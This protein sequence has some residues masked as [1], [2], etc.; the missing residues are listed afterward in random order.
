MCDFGPL[1]E[2]PKVFIF[3]HHGSGRHFPHDGT[4]AA[5]SASTFYEAASIG[6]IGAADG[7]TSIYVATRFAPNL[8][9]ADLRGSLHIHGAGAAHPAAGHHGAYTTHKERCMKMPPAHETGHRDARA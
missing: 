3:G 6:I 9:G 7:P 2:N 4:G 8:L 1:L 5:S